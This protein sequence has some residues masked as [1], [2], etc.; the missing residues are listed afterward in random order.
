M[1]HVTTQHNDCMVI[2]FS[3]RLCSGKCGYVYF[4][5]DSC[6]PNETPCVSSCEGKT[7]GDY[8]SCHGCDVY[9]TCVHGAPVDDRPCPRGLVWDDIE[10]RC[11]WES[12]TCSNCPGWLSSLF[13]IIL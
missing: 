6:S 9:V 12:K 3:V 7:N 4:L 8:Q 1:R 13:N 10:K 11:E 2:L 5:G